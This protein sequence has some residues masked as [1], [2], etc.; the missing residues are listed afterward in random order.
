MRALP[1]RPPRT[2]LGLAPEQV[3]VLSTGVI[4]APLPLERIQRGLATAV[5]QLSVDGGEL[6]AEAILTTDTVIEDVGGARRRILRRRH[7]QG[8]GDD[9]PEPRDDARRR[10]DRLPARGGRG[11]LV[12]APG[13]RRELQ[14]DLGRR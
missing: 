3:I 8:L 1:P 6:A 13:R 12:P 14:R 11:D 4:G 7:G 2:L 10:H 9:P 5:S